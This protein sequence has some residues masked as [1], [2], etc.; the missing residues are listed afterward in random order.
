M[1]YLP[2][3]LNVQWDISIDS[4]RVNPV[5]W[6]QRILDIALTI[7]NIS[8]SVTFEEHES[9]EYP[10]YILRNRE[11][12]RLFNRLSGFYFYTLDDDNILHPAFFPVISHYIQKEP[13]KA[14]VFATIFQRENGPY[15]WID[16]YLVRVPDP[17]FVSPTQIDI[18]QY[19][20]HSTVIGDTRFVLGNGCAD[21]IF[22][23][24]LFSNKRSEF[25][26]IHQ[27]LAYYN[28]LNPMKPWVPPLE[29]GL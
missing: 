1:C 6:E 24:T 18:A 26:F 5:E 27:I 13:N 10:E 17:A 28:S 19:V 25:V 11:L 9:I 23:Q 8:V 22:I 4:N 15:P 14:Y 3:L 21:G 29:I 7:D 12:E 16:S 2:E 20:V